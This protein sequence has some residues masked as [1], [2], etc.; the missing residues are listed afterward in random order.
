[1]SE[2]LARYLDSQFAPYEDSPATRE[3]KEELLGNLREKLADYK[4]QGCDDETAYYNT[5]QSVGDIGEII[6]TLPA[7]SGELLEMPQK[8]FSDA[9][10][11]N[12]DLKRVKIHYG[13]FDDSTLRG[14][15]LRG[16]DLTGS[17]FDSADLKNVR[18]DGANL[19]GAKIYEADLRGATLNGCRF[20]N[21]IFAGSDLSGVQFDN[22]T[23]TGTIFDEAVLK[24]TSFKN[25]IFREVSF[26][27]AI[28]IRKANF[29][30]AIMDRH[31]YASLKA[32]NAHL[33][34]VTLV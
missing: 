8:D 28:D 30:G 23:F 29:E 17:S 16:S 12:R 32:G 18:F 24:G 27:E 21:T 34:N 5:V 25:A 10:L 11:R 9:D 15:D 19:S 14:A 7:G 22:Q 33:G 20:D 31:T 13:L 6:K 2:Q 4:R 1:M 3:L 26:R